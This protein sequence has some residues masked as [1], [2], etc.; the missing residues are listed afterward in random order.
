MKSTYPKGL[1]GGLSKTVDKKVLCKLH[2]TVQML[3]IINVFHMALK[4]LIS[5]NFWQNK[6]WFP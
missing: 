6:L 2:G 3:M 1:L 4:G 5:H